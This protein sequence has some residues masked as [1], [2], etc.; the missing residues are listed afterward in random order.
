MRE[1]AK[2]LREVAKV[3]VVAFVIWLAVGSVYGISGTDVVRSPLYNDPQTEVRVAFVYIPI[4]SLVLAFLYRALLG[5][6]ETIF[7]FHLEDWRF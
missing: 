2:V 4:A 1:V 3:L 6:P 7:G 5:F